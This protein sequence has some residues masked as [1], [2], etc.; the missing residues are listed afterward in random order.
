MSPLPSPPGNSTTP[1]PNSPFNY[2]DQQFLEG[3]YSP[4]L[5]GEGLQVQGDYL[6]T[7]SNNAV[8]ITEN[9]TLYVSTLG[10]DATGDGSPSNPWQSPHKAMEVLSKYIIW[11]GVQV[12]IQCAEGIYNFT[13]PL[14]VDYPYGSQV[15]IQGV[16][17]GPRPSISNLTSAGPGYNNTTKNYNLS[18]LQ[19]VYK[20]VFAFSLCNGVE[21]FNCSG[22][23]LNDLLIA[24]APASNTAGVCAGKVLEKVGSFYPSYRVQPSTATIQLGNVA[25]WGW[26]MAGVLAVGGRV[27]FDPGSGIVCG[28]NDNDG[29]FGG[30]LLALANGVIS[31]TDSYVVNNQWGWAA[32]EGGSISGAGLS[33]VFANQNGIYVAVSGVADVTNGNC[34]VNVD[35]ALKIVNAGTIRGQFTNF[36]NIPTTGNFATINGAGFMDLRQAAIDP[37]AVFDPP[38]DTVGNGLGFIRT[39]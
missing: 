37:S 3:A 35:E 24:G 28:C 26:T 16:V 17:T 9:T 7:A 13:T 4:V 6:K 2:P 5:V 23:T 27:Y 31:P 39:V 32:A 19:T 14:N 29:Y 1:I 25:I 18:V 21:A 10:N 34:A 33:Y 11:E 36:G 12:I 20:T 30:G 38:V 8:A 15:V 22:V